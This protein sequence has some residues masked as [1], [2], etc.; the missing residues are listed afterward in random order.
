MITCGELDDEMFARLNTCQYCYPALRV[1]EIDAINAA[2]TE[3]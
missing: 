3:N 2:Y 1:E